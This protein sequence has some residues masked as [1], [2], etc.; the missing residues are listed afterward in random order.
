MIA[1]VVFTIGIVF[2]YLYTINEPNEAQETIDALY[3][4]GK[5]IADSVLSEGYPPGWNPGN[6]V[7]T[8]ILSQGKINETKLKNFNELS[9]TPAG[10]A[11]AKNLFNTRYDYYFNL[12]TA[13]NI[14]GSPVG[15]IGMLPQNVK[16]LVKITRFTVYQNKPATAYLYV[17]GK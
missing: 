11:K 15:G 7:T 16:N 12:S 17:F 8:G 5:I 10:Y 3:Y 6:V 4:D 13:I 9:S 1:S 2:F 14:D